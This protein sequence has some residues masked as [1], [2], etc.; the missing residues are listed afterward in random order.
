[1]KITKEWLLEKKACASGVK[2]FESQKETDIVRVLESLNNDD[3][4]EWANWLMVRI[5]SYKQYVSSAVYAT[6][7][8]LD[9]FE[10][11]YPDDDRPR[12]AIEAA[13]KCIDDPS[14]ENK[15]AA[16]DAAADVAASADSAAYAAAVAAS[17]AYADAADAA[18]V[19]A[20]NAAYVAADAAA[21][22]AAVPFVGTAS[23]ADAYAAAKKQM[24]L[25][26]LN[27]GI[28]IIEEN[29]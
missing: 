4:W 15:Q 12:K 16:A 2:W 11:K 5:M 6:E 22:A 23:Y 18:Y 9:I 28:K 13:R 17:A 14:E 1:M 7:Q 25:K 24:R 8:V 19:A 20:A 26:I 29:L 21:V 27:Y 10:D 3:H